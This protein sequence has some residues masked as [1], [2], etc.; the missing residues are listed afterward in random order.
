MFGLIYAAVRQSVS[1]TQLVAAVSATLL[2]SKIYFRD[3]LISQKVTGRVFITIRNALYDITYSCMASSESKTS[4]SGFNFENYQ[5][6][7]KHRKFGLRDCCLAKQLTIS[8]HLNIALVILFCTVIPHCT[9]KEQNTGL[10]LISLDRQY[11]YDGPI[12]LTDRL[13]PI[14]S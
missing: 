2:L 9:G 5:A 12:L 13:V 6:E 10:K 3:V 11:N 14:C 4:V 1:K 7:E 8:T